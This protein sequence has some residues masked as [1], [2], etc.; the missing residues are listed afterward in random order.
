MHL[1]N[2]H[3]LFVTF[4]HYYKVH[5]ITQ[6]HIKC[7]TDKLGTYQNVIKP[8]IFILPH[9]CWLTVGLSTKTCIRLKRVEIKIGRENKRYLK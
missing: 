9:F 2:F 1:F 4:V 3:F 5:A 6:C 8:N 7:Q